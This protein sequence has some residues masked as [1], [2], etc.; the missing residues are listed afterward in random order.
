MALEAIA[1]VEEA[2]AAAIRRK[3][4]AAQQARRL[5]VLTQGEGEQALEETKKKISDQLQQM[6]SD[7]EARIRTER[8]RVRGE[9]ESEL[10]I[11]RARAE[12][13]LDQAAGKIMERIVSG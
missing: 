8:D 7:A 11:L 10:S 1:A 2:E 6:E 9:T 3:T 12:S 13:R 5:A 4:E